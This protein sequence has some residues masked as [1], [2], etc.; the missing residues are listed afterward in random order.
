MGL[1]C[2]LLLCVASR[3]RA[4][5]AEEDEV[6]R[7]APQRVSGAVSGG[8][9]QENRL[10]IPPYMRDVRGSATTTAF[11]PV[12]F[13]R[14]SDKEHERLVLPYYYKRSSKLSVDVALGLVWSLRGPNRNTFVLPPLYTHRSGKDWGVGLLPLFSTGVFSGH[15]HTVIPPLLTWI[16]GEGETRRT[17]VGPFFDFRGE[18]GRKWGLFP[19]VWGKGEASDRYIVVP[20][21]FWH[22]AEDDPLSATT[23]VVPFYH[24]RRKEE[25]SWGLVPLV[26]GSASPKLRSL[27]VPFLLFH[28][29]N[30]PDE[31]RLVTPLMSHFSDEDGSSW[32]TPIYQRKRGDKGFDAVAPFFFH[33][34]DQRDMSSG[35]FVPPIFWRWR[36]PANET[37]VVFPFFGRGYRAGIRNTWVTPLLAHS[38]NLDKKGQTWWVLPTFHYADD[39]T[40]WQFNIHPLVYRKKATDHSHLVVAP[41]VWD[42]RNKEKQWHRSVLFPLWWNFKNYHKQTFSRSLPPLYWDFEDKKLQK[43]SLVGFPLYWDFANGSIKKRTT[44]AFPLYTRLERGASVGHLVLNTYFERRDQPNHK[45]WQFHF[46]PLLALGRGERGKED[47]RFWSLFYGLAGYERRGKYRRATAFWIPFNMK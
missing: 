35:L 46:F 9:S 42:F 36:D 17:V 21:L 39:E 2:L 47:D 30:G 45:S 40:S 26:F 37:L 28:H 3:G 11:F 44:V 25:T 32:Y 10:I 18:K 33:T 23:V 4:D 20:P 12:Y 24:K 43:R 15:H 31:F 1:G 34:W 13:D 19:L 27:T 38:T 8:P 6:T 22:F 16:D 41:I 5:G 7:P 29:A 14:L